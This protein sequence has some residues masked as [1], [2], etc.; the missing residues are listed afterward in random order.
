[1]RQNLASKNNVEPSIFYL[2]KQPCFLLLT[3]QK[4]T[5]IRPHLKNYFPQACQGLSH[6]IVEPATLESKLCFEF[7]WLRS[8]AVSTQFRGAKSGW[9]M[10]SVMHACVLTPVPHAVCRQECSSF[11]GANKDSRNQSESAWERPTR[12]LPKTLLPRILGAV[13]LKLPWA[14]TFT[15][16]MRSSPW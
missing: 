10:T 3:P 1:M 2:K 12:Y 8:L 11:L 14:R 6:G 7:V 16:F 13:P 9:S 4:N 5:R 15:L